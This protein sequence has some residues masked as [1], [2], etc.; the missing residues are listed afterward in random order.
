MPIKA[1]SST[2]VIIGGSS[3]PTT[4]LYSTDSGKIVEIFPNIVIDSLEDPRLRVYDV[5]TYE[6]VSPYFILPGLVDSH[7]H[8][9]EPGRTEWEGFATG[10]KA[11]CSGG[12]TTVVDMPLNAIP[13]TTTVANFNMKLKAAKE[14]LWCDVA[15]WGGLVPTNL[16]DLLPLVKA[17]V[18]GFKG[19]LIDSGVD[20]F[21]AINKAYIQEAMKVLADCETIMMFHAE[22][23]IDKHLHTIVDSD[24]ITKI[25]SLDGGEDLTT[26]QIDSLALSHILSPAEPRTGAPSHIVHH[27]DISIPALEAAATFDKELAKV[28]PRKYSS[29][30][31][32]RPD[33]FES[34]AISLIIS[35]LEDSIK[36]NKGKVPP[37]HIVHLASMEALP[38]IR[39]A[40]KRGLP[41]TVETCFHYLSLAAENIPK[42]ATYFKCCPPIR[43]EANRVALWGALREGLIT[44]VVSDHSPCTPE[45]KHLA[46]G[47][48]FSAWGGISSV[49]LGLPLLYSKGSSM[50]PPVSLID[51]VKWCC[52]N[53]AK[54]IGLQHCKGYLAVGHDADFIVFDAEREQEI[55]NSNL[56]FKNKLTAYNGFRLQGV[57]LTTYLRGRVIFDGHNGP[58]R[59]PLGK[60]ILEPRF[61]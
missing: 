6:N 39:R 48:F 21:P 4:I 5:K 31:I 52:E 26:K 18:R 35:C 28:D 23:Q 30:L 58:S 44:S 29:F 17:G 41:I 3:V 51:I 59:T 8:L 9:N 19:F 15:F 53:T 37:V 43:T 33:R 49:G 24:N 57:V 46:K 25:R 60:A 11:A 16:G 2:N 55:C 13:P 45:L 7:V 54:Q 40:H 47:D 50:K 10:T 34:D 42:S 12:V 36:R 27:D 32:S 38:L 56:Y 20:E 1:I 22:L 61:A 14:Q